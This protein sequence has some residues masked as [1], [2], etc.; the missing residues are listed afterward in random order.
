MCERSLVTKDYHREII[1]KL[2]FPNERPY[3]II[4]VHTNWT[5]GIQR[6]KVTEIINIR[7]LGIFNK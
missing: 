1:R 2:E 4:Q 5:L 3:K 7:R 6:G